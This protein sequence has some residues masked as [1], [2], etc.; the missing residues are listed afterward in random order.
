MFV[1][2]AIAGLAL[3][4]LAAT[5]FLISPPANRTYPGAIPWSDD[6][7]LHF[8]TR[9]MGAF[10]VL[11]SIRGV[12]VK[13]LALHVTATLGLLVLAWRFALRPPT[14]PATRVERIA[15]TAQY[16][17]GAWILVTLTTCATSTAPLLALGQTALYALP[18]AWA[19]CI[20][21]T[22]DRRHVP[23]ILAGVVGLTTL[24]AIL[25][26]WYF[27]ERNPHHRLGFPI[28]NPTTLAACLIPAVLICVARLGHAITTQVRCRQFGLDGVT[29]AAGLALI[30]LLW[31]FALTRGRAAALALIVGLATMLVFTTARRWRWLTAGGLSV[32][33]VGAGLALY[34]A[35]RLDV[36]MSRGA[37]IRFR[38]YAW[39][40]AAE[41]WSSRPFT[42][43]GA[44]C[45]PR[46]AGSLAAR[47]RALDPG[48]FMGQLVEHAH[49]ELFEIFAEIGLGGG[50]TYVAGWVATL[51]AAA[52]VL[53][54]RPPN[55]NAALE[56]ALVASIVALLADGLVG[57]TLRLPGP[58]AVLF[59]LLGVLWATAR[60]RPSCPPDAPRKP[61]TQRT[62]VATCL[63]AAIGAGWLASTNW[64]AVQNEYDARRAFQREQYGAA[65]AAIARAERGLLDPVA[66]LIARDLAL[67]CQFQRASRALAHCTTQNTTQPALPD[68]QYAHELARTTYDMTRELEQTIPALQRTRAVAARAAEFLATLEHAAGNAAAVRYWRQRAGQAWQG[69]RQLTPYDV[70]T[71]LAL[72][73]YQP[74]PQTHMSLLRDALRSLA[75]GDVERF[76]D[77][78]ER[79]HWY[80]LWL[81]SLVQLM[82]QPSFGQT[83]DA[84]LAGAGPITPDTD[85]DALIASMAPEIHRLAA[86]SHALQG[87]FATAASGSAQAATLYAP[88]RSR[89][90]FLHS[91][92]LA[93][94]AQYTLHADPADARRAADLLRQAIARLPVIQ[95]QKYADAIKPYEHIL[96]RTL[97]AA[98]DETAARALLTSDAV[99]PPARQLADEYVALAE[100]FIREKTGR[101]EQID[102]WLRAALGHIPDH[103]RAWS[104][105]AWLAADANDVAAIEALLDEAADAGISASDRDRIRSSLIQEFP[106]LRDALGSG[107]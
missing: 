45:Y 53:R 52:L 11:R 96:L 83:L 3:A 78:A 15:R 80:R 82:Q 13:E 88:L 75:I 90:P 76:P 81:G 89:F 91:T 4:L 7:I 73:S 22:L 77:P 38:L 79:D 63:A 107:E 14:R 66:R 9:A 69:Q 16:A 86:A 23:R 65:A 99:G 55:A 12:E 25:G 48:A 35:S 31:C 85:V 24:T 1:S 19:V 40:Y 10:G 106:H 50:V 8:I 101:A 67:H 18:L 100:F 84:F 54:P 62:L 42:G 17:F 49:N 71:L 36:T 64:R 94:Q 57:A 74:T 43:H 44:G 87:D 37:T 95:E 34:A 26:I 32:A 72:T 58:P 2:Q 28:G 68:W 6:S 21:H 92:A 98:G 93:E 61:W 60:T 56:L 29:L 20:A 105:R 46:L 59:T 27:T 5:F 103:L 47:D 104:W 102:H 33:I 41:L 70:Q 30:P 39:R 97:L 51:F